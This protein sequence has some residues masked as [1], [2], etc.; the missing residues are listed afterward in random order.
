VVCDSSL[1]LLHCLVSLG[2]QAAGIKDE[3]K[4]G[5]ELKNSSEGLNGGEDPNTPNSE[6]D[7][8]RAELRQSWK[9]EISRMEGSMRSHFIN[10]SVE[11][12]LVVSNA[13]EDEPPA[14]PVKKGNCCFGFWNWVEFTEI[15]K[16]LFS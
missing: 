10:E 9:M 2:A 16:I 15:A 11:A 4:L 12:G 8:W 5:G 6:S 7:A 1:L 14:L 13:W 3:L